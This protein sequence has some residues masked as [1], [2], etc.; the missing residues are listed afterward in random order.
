MYRLYH[1]D[2]RRGMVLESNRPNTTRSLQ[3]NLGHGKV[4]VKTEVPG[5]AGNV[6][7]L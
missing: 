7:Q 3:S 6:A 5:I 2:G 1:T 4:R